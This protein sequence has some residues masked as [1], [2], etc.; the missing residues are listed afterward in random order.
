[1]TTRLYFHC[2]NA[3]ETWVDS[4]GTEVRGLADAGRHAM[5]IMR[6]LIAEPTLE[7]WRNWTLQVSDEDGEPL[8]SVP[9]VSALGKPH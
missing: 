8:L 4:S 3:R 6:A 9:F 2:S 7:D 1:M 5:H